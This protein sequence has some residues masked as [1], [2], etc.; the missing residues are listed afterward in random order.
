MVPLAADAQPAAQP[1]RSQ[2]TAHLIGGNAETSQAVRIVVGL[3]VLALLPAILI[4]VTAFLRIII[5]LSML[6]HAIGM[7]ETPPNM[8]LIGLALFLRIYGAPDA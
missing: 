7:P 4:C 5:V 6:R 1:A 8:V 2:A 3:T